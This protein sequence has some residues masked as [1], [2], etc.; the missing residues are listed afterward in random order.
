MKDKIKE[1]IINFTEKYSANT[2][3]DWKEPL[4]AFA[5]SDDSLFGQMKKI[6]SPTHALP[7][8]F[9][10]EANTVITYF[11]PFTKDIGDSNIDGKF[12]SYKWAV[13]YIETNQLIHNINH[14]IHEKLEEM[15]YN[16]TII[17]ATHNFDEE[18][19][20]SDWSHRHAA[21][22]AG[23]GTFGVNNMLI[24]EKG[25]C[26]R[27]GSIVTDLEIIPDNRP[28]KEHC[29]YKRDGSCLVCVDHCVNDALFEGDFDRHKCYEMCL[30]NDDKYGDMDTTDVCG[31]CVVGLPCTYRIPD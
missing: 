27:V 14:Y 12:A 8:D 20:I 16:S 3:S 31:K 28:E 24:T 22:I 10:S 30:I 19:L 1:M 29:L 6:I 25:C 17:P 15:G 5:D 23:L 13:A 11:L 9:L 26:G 21:Y 7:S 4:I 18:K 2:E